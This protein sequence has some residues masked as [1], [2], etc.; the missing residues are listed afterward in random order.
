MASKKENEE[1]GK[2]RDKDNADWAE[3]SIFG[4]HKD[5]FDPKR[6]ITE[7]LKD[8]DNIQPLPPERPKKK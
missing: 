3:S 4:P 1:K 7:P 6:K 8:P 2:A 5:T